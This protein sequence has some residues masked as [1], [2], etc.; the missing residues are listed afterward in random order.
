MR[1]SY[2]RKRTNQTKTQYLGINSWNSQKGS[3]FHCWKVHFY[4]RV[5]APLS[6]AMPSLALKSR[7]NVRKGFMTGWGKAGDRLL[8]KVW[9]GVST[10]PKQSCSC[11]TLSQWEVARLAAKL[12]SMLMKVKHWYHQLQLALNELPRPQCQSSSVLICNSFAVPALG[13]FYTK[14]ASQSE[15]TTPPNRVV[16]HCEASFKS[17]W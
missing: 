7:A 1:D 8:K 15:Q 17:S 14:A 12:S 3:I 9:E 16:I 6:T 5:L 13:L 2:L 10:E 4:G 11:I